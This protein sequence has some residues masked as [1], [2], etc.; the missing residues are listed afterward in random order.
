[1]TSEGADAG[2]ESTEPE[3]AVGPPATD[4]RWRT[5]A[6]IGAAAGVFGIPAVAA[7]LF[8]GAPLSLIVA[9]S[10][11]AAAGAMA[12]RLR[13]RASVYAFAAML[14]L[15]IAGVVYLALFMLGAWFIV[16]ADERAPVVARVIAEASIALGSGFLAV[17]AL[18]VARR[19]APAR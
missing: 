2:Q 17:A 7:A 18:E 15:V 1:M 4:S 9:I 8:A 13:S 12:R 10:V 5:A 16:A 11:A 3:A 14:W 19:I 6:L